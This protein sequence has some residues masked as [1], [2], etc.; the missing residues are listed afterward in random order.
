MK[1]V[2]LDCLGAALA[3]YS[4]PIGKIIT[5]FV[6]ESGGS[7]KATV[8]GAGFKTSP[9][10]A[11]LANGTM[12]HALDYDDYSLV[13]AGH[14]SVSLLPSILA[15]GEDRGISGKK[16]L[17]AYIVGFEIES[18]LGAGVNFRHYELGWHATCT[19]GTLG[20]AA[21]CSSILGLDIE[22]TRM[23]LGIAASEAS[24]L[25]QNF[26]TMTKPF[27][28]G[29]SARNGVIAALL[30]EKGFTADKNILEAEFGFC[31][32]FCGKG[33][34]DSERITSNLGNPFAI[35]EPGISIK[36]YPSCGGTHTALDAMLYLA[37]ENDINPSDVEEIGVDVPELLPRVLIHSN[38]KTGL[39][40]NSVW[41][42]VWQ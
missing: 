20:A 36:P 12:A 1:R 37:K 4:H 9:H 13:L 25:R 33:E 7:P 2:S 3:G 40:G 17:T 28:A 32:L 21:A 29:L 41:S 24:G 15:I 38:P 6:K 42:S 35:F 31:N 39:E 27:H 5:D 16:V 23:A 19:L 22:K 10:E 14:P 18:K 34:Y 26:G 8:I 30:A 11:A